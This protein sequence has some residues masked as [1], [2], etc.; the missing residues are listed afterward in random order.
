M[1]PLS[2]VLPAV[3]CSVQ[4]TFLTGR[5]PS[6]HG[7]VANGWYFRDLSEVW[8]WR[9]SNRLV[10]GDKVWHEAKRRDPSFTCANL[11][12]WYAMAADCGTVVT[13]RPAYHADGR[14]LPDVWTDPPELKHALNQQLG[15][16]PLFDFWGPKA[17]LPSSRWIA[18]A[19][20][21]VLSH[22]KPTLTLVYLPHLDYD[23]QR[24][25]PHDARIAPQVREVDA[26]AGRV[27]DAARAQGCEVVVL[28]EYAITPVTR[29][30][31][32][33]ALKPLTRNRRACCRLPW[34]QRRSRLA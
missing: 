28:S 24:Y 26:V 13:P 18:D 11:F 4:S 19:A 17:G 30:P 7:I 34:H 25:G 14:K 33:T 12:W 15:R 5:L 2:T 8:L 9:Q 22:A 27:V 32:L 29:W 6:Q 21:H 31:R 20:I 16:F 3:T 10:Q 1:A 23:L